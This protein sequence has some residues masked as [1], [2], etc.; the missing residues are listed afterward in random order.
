MHMTP[1][2]RETAHFVLERKEID[3]SV[4]AG[5][6]IVDV[7]V[8]MDWVGDAPPEPAAAKT[9]DTAPDSLN[10]LEDAQSEGVKVQD[11]A[12]DI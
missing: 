12:D 9:T 8:A 6:W 3:F 1:G 11:A 2:A 5:A 10:A 4:G 7:D